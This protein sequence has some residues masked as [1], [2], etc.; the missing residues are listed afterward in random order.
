MT[1][2]NDI[3]KLYADLHKDVPETRPKHEKRGP[4]VIYDD[5][6][7]NWIP[8]WENEFMDERGPYAN[9]AVALCRC[10]ALSFVVRSPKIIYMPKVP[11]PNEEAH[12]FR[13]SRVVSDT[14]AWMDK[15]A[16][17]DAELIRICHEIK[18]CKEAG[19]ALFGAIHAA[20]GKTK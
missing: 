15:G 4:L 7:G 13:C 2:A 8:C 14:I 9:E 19:E 1:D 5:T 12:F 6:Y 20:K 17:D 3:L 10:A 18:S 11:L 16:D